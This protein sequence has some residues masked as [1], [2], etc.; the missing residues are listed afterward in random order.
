M[1]PVPIAS[2]K[3]AVIA[4]PAL[5]GRTTRANGT[6]R[7]GPRSGSSDIAIWCCTA[8]HRYCR[9]SHRRF[10]MRTRKISDSPQRVTVAAAELRRTISEPTP[11]IWSWQPSLDPAPPPTADITARIRRRDREGLDA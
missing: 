3:S 10:D 5:P 9:R 11:V 1:V 4:R 2:A 6:E 8:R 7:A